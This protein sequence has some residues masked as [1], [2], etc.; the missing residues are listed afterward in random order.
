MIGLVVW[1][2]RL[3]LESLGSKWWRR[4]L[5]RCLGCGAVLRKG[6]D[7]YTCGCGKSYPV[8][9]NVPILLP[10]VKTSPASAPVTEVETTRVITAFGIK[11][12]ASTRQRIAA[13]LARTYQFADSFLEA[14]N[15]YLLQRL[16]I[17]R[18]ARA[19]VEALAEPG[20]GAVAFSVIRHYVPAALVCGA[21][22]SHN[23]RIR[24]LGSEPL[25]RRA[26]D[27]W[28]LGLRLGETEADPTPLPV[29]VLAGREITLPVR[30]L[31]PTAAGDYELTVVLV[32]Q[33]GRCLPA[34]ERF[35]V[36]VQSN[37]KRPYKALDPIRGPLA[38]DYDADHRIGIGIVERAVN[39]ARARR[40]LE[41]ASSAS[42]ATCNLGCLT[43]NIDIDA[44]TMQ[45]ADVVFEKRGYSN[46][47]FA[48]C[49]AL[50]LPFADAT[51]DFVSTFAALHHFAD[52]VTV[53]REAVRV[54]KPGGFVAVMCEPTGHEFDR[55]H[56][57]LVEVLEHGVNE[58]IFSL[59]EYARMFH[60]AGLRPTSSQLDD[61]SLKVILRR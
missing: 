23:V 43:V 52:P 27:G 42:P 48:C 39:L 20:S 61:D 44:Q 50:H 16:A 10:E 13:I 36:A 47:I 2:D 54:V 22:T 9:A 19:S 25:L 32:H 21:A 1:L 24:N 4:T 8:L 41:I 57:Q 34:S 58:Q 45:M 59:D 3:G 26:R 28:S 46:V 29:T 5:F 14:E 18:E 49:D 30:L 31:A 7:T 15:N 53:L 37:V 35:P 11:D 12:E 60:T 40:G 6:P 38:A 17:N 51:F 33:D 56:P 55:P